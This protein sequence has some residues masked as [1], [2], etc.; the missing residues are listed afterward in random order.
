MGIHKRNSSEHFYSLDRIFIRIP[1]TDISES[2]LTTI[3]PTSVTS[4]CYA[5]GV[6]HVIYYR[7]CVTPADANEL[8]FAS[9]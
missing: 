4:H 8:K 3:I 2:V 1:P 9:L 5:E 6:N 7:N